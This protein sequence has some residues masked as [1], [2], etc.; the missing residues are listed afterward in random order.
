M[1][2][3]PPRELPDP[4]PQMALRALACGLPVEMAELE[5][6]LGMW[7]TPTETIWNRWVHTPEELDEFIALWTQP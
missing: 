3:D 4:L 5:G 7:V 1:T 2:W 6:V